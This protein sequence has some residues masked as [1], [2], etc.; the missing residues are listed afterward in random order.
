MQPPEQRRG[1]DHVQRQRRAACRGSARRTAP[2]PRRS[3]RAHS[4]TAPDA[5]NCGPGRSS[6]SSRPRCCRA[7]R[8]CRRAAGICIS[9]TWATACWPQPSRG[10]S[11]TR[12]A[13]ERFGAA[14]VA[15][16]L[17]PEG[18]ACRAS[19]DSR[20]C[21]PTRPAGARDAVAQHARI[22]GEE[23]DL[24]AGKQRQRI[25]RRLDRRRPRARGRPRASGARRDGRAP[26]H[27]RARVPSQAAPTP[28][29]GMPSRPAP[30]R[31]RWRGR[32]DSLSAHAP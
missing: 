6:P 13:A 32:R 3:R 1:V 2:A 14:V 10:S 26:R 18:H 19:S 16:F 15:G 8:R 17:Q 23:I 20:A 28:R 29:R 4:G 31:G 24:M 5:T 22:A 9:S 21:L 30:P 12:L 27:G 7:S 25:A 11:A